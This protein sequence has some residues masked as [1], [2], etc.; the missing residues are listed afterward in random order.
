[1]EFNEWRDNDHDLDDESEHEPQESEG[2]TERDPPKL[3]VVEGHY[4]TVQ[5]DTGLTSTNPNLDLMVIY[6]K[7]LKNFP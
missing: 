5:I 2:E 3:V 7:F 6:Y 4:E 1:M